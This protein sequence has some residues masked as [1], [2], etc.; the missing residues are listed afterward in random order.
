[1]LA[2]SSRDSG[3]LGLRRPKTKIP[4][5]AGMNGMGMGPSIEEGRVGYST[6]QIAPIENLVEVKP[7][8]TGVGLASP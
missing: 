4:T 7:G 3:N 1:M 2:P 6:C 5:F 8:S